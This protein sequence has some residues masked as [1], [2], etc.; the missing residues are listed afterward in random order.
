MNN[1]Y[2][3]PN[4]TK[5]GMKDI[6]ECIVPQLNNLGFNIYMDE[7]SSCI[8]NNAPY[9]ILTS[10]QE[11][12]DAA[13]CLVVIGG[14]GTIL[15]IAIDAAS[16]NKPVLGINMGTL[17]F[18][19]ELEIEEINLIKALKT[20]DFEY[21]NRL[22]LDIS[23]IAA[24]GTVKFKRTA[25]NETAISKGSLSKMIELSVHV[26]DKKA[27]SF[28]GDGLIVCSPT[29]STAYS[30]SAGGPILDPSCSCIAVTP[31]CPHSLNIKSFVLH[32]DN[33][34]EVN[35]N[36][37]SNSAFIL[38]DGSEPVQLNQDDRIIIEKSK[39]SLS[40]IRIKDLGFYE[41]IR[42]KLSGERG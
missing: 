6:V 17:G 18:I 41:I 15:R 34:I 13:D 20:D 40:L 30:L 19:P 8:P 31:I 4:P 1:L 11:A 28:S 12:I 25:L 36:P 3:H 16:A 5:A 33:K 23:V 27:M 24:D 37:G 10:F 2:V 9:I 14:D 32:S 38:A 22:M 7:R 26:S 29:G 39:L 21:D 42:R 35:V